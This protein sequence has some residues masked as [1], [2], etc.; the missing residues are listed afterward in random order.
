[1]KTGN[2]QRGDDGHLK[3]TDESLL[4]SKMNELEEQTDTDVQGP[5]MTHTLRQTFSHASERPTGDQ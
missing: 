4:R 2:V 5:S 3:Q 1:M